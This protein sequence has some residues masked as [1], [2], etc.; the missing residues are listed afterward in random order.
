MMK[1]SLVFFT[2]FTLIGTVFSQESP[3]STI[4]GAVMIDSA[5]DNQTLNVVV[6]RVF[7]APAQDVWRAWTDPDFVMKWWGPVGFTSP[8]A[9]IDSREG[10][11]SLVCMRSPDGQDMY[12]TWTYRKIVPHERIEYIFNFADQDG[13]KLDPVAL[14]L[15]PGIPKDGHHVV[16][17]K[18]LADGKTE[19]TITE[20]G[21]TSE[22][23]V[24]MSK[25]GLE[26]C[27]DKMAALFRKS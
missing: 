12:S 27:V 18:S 3:Q 7:D 4:E 14:G 20:H 6:T 16:V 21:Y 17:F 19:M 8:V 25:A 23:T 24:A 22:Q 26:Q 15:P 2:M 1:Y 11:K 9:K 10:G 5:K 13:N